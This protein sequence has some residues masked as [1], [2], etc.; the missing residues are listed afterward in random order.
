M[1]RMACC[2]GG[3]YLEPVPGVAYSGNVV[4]HFVKHFV[5]MAQF[6]LS[7]RQSVRPSVR[8]RSPETEFSAN[9]IQL[10]AVVGAAT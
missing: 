10:P 4:A 8:R 6:R 3:H 9:I 2:R 5:D 7:L 1:D